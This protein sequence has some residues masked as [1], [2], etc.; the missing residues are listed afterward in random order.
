MKWAW[1]GMCQNRMLVEYYDSPLFHE[2]FRSISH[3][4]SIVRGGGGLDY[5]GVT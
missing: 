2:E 3:L 1:G 5:G 4:Q